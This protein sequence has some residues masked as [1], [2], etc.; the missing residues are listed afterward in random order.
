MLRREADED[1][2]ASSHMT[3]MSANQPPLGSI[4]DDLPFVTDYGERTE[5]MGWFLFSNTVYGMIV[6]GMTFVWL[7]YVGC[8]FGPLGALL[9]GLVSFLL[10][11]GLAGR[12][13]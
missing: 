1:P 2:Q 3:L 11:Y 9:G 5:S 6:G 7:P 4:A 13:R 10:A 8:V 12:K